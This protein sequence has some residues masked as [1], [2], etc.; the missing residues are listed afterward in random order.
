MARCPNCGAEMP[1]GARYCPTCGA[2]LPRRPGPQEQP[3]LPFSPFGPPPMALQTAGAG[4]IGRAEPVTGP[5]L[6]G[7][8]VGIAVGAILLF[9]LFIV[10]FGR[11]IWG[12]KTQTAAS[13]GGIP[14]LGMKG[15]LVKIGN[16]ALGVA[17]TDT[18]KQ[19]DHRQPVNGQFFAVGVIIANRGNQPFTL[20]DDALG[21][22]NGKGKRYQPVLT[23]W[24]T[25]GQLDAGHYV[26]R[27]I[28]SPQESIA[29]IIV[30]DT[31][32]DLAQQKLLVRDLTQESTDFTGAID[33]TQEKK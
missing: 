12:R 4:A 2:A 26:T 5:P 32:R 25:P 15:E 13:S 27:Y 14:T 24:G 11:G 33:L 31:P 1:A 6:T 29:G 8:Q 20:A 22:I 10:F 3:P 21:L 9:M 28:L 16:M 17:F 23:A 30:F 7:R 18:A 19:L